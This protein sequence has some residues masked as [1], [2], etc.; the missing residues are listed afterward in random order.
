M[1]YAGFGLVTKQ[2]Y[3]NFLYNIFVLYVLFESNQQSAFVFSSLL[4]YVHF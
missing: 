4:F 1:Y 3:M 2:I